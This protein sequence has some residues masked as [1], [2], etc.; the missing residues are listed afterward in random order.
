M[1]KTAVPD[2]NGSQ[3]MLNGQLLQHN[4][5][6]QCQIMAVATASMSDV[7]TLFETCSET[8]RDQRTVNKLRN[9]QRVSK[10]N[11]SKYLCQT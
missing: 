6:Q 5:L 7:H 11:M 1:L 9:T 2:G 3:R 10:K 4:N 8:S